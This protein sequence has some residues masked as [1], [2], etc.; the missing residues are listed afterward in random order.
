MVT[1]AYVDSDGIERTY[2]VGLEPVLV[3]RAPECEIRSNDPLVSRKHARLYAG[4]DGTLF[5]EDLGSANGVFVGPNRVQISSIPMG[6]VVVVGSLRFRQLAVALASCA[7]SSAIRAPYASRSSSTVRRALR[8]TSRR[9][10]SIAYASAPGAASGAGVV[11]PRSGS[12]TAWVR[13]GT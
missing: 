7:C 9:W 3:G 13:R 8:S 2:V 12:S 6:A 5:I 10:M 11:A 1:V 4:Q